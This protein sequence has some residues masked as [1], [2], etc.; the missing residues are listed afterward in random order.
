MAAAQ[1]LLSAK[2]FTW[3]WRLVALLPAKFAN[4]FNLWNFCYGHIVVSVI[5]V[6]VKKVMRDLQVT[7]FLDTLLT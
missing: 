7:D 1:T 4:V 5:S 6:S 3:T 2:V